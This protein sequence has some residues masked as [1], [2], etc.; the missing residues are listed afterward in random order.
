MLGFT[1]FALKRPVTVLLGLLTL[2]YFGLQS[3]LGSKVELTPEMEMPVM[4]VAT[5]YAGASP[6]DINDLI[7]RPVEDAVATLSGIDEV[8]TYSMENVSIAI[9]QY[10]YGTNMDSAYL[11]LK[12]A[13]DG[14]KSG[15]PEEADEANIIEMDVNAM[16]VVTMAIMGGTDGN[17]YNYVNNEIIP[18][19]E[20]LSSVGEVSLAGGRESYVRIELMAEEMNQYHLDMNTVAQIV[21][22]ADFA[23][24]AGSTKVGKE[25]LS[26]SGGND[27][28]DVESLKNIPIPLADGN[29]IHL[30]DIANVYEALE[31]A[32]SIGRY[33]GQDVISISIQK[34]QSAS[35]VDV[36]RQVV[37][38]MEALKA[39][40]PSL[41]YEMINDSSE[42]IVSSIK[43]V[44]QTLIMAV[45]LSMIVL[46]VFFGDMKASLIVGS[47][48]PV[49]VVVALILMSAM[50]YSLNVISLGALVLGVGMMVDNSIV[51]LES[52][53]RSKEKGGTV[54]DIVVEGARMVINS[55]I[56]ST[57]T[58]CV[59]FIP[60]AL[61]EGLSGQL[62]KPLGF[63][64]VFCMTASLF[65]AVIV[66]P[67]MYMFINPVERTETPVNKG[68]RRL[69]NWYR[70]NIVKLIP[71]TKTVL[72]SSIGLL[73]F[74]LF[75]AS[76][77]GMELMPQ[78]DEGIVNVTITTK[79][80]LTV[81][82]NNEILTKL[83]D[84]VMN[85]EDVDHYLLTY[86]ASGLSISAADAS[87]LTAYLK[88]DRQ[89]S[90]DEVMQK[91]RRETQDMTDC[92]VTIENGSSTGSS[93]MSST[94]TIE[95]DIEGVDYDEVKAVAEDMAAQLKERPDVTQVHS[96]V[97]NAAP[98]VKV[99][100]DPIKA[101]A[102]GLT[103]ASV[104]SVI[105]STLSGVTAMTL[106]T[107]GEDIDVKVEFA[108]DEYDNINQLEGI[109]LTTPAGT[110]VP[111]SDIADIY[112]QDS[113]QT[114]QRSDK[115]YQVAIT[116]QPVEGYEETAETDV[117][118]F[119]AAYTFPAGVSNAA[120]AMDEMMVEELSGLMGA[121]GTAI[122][123][124][125]VV[126]AM[127]FESPKF[128]F[129]VMF[130]IPFSLI[131]AFGCLFIA[132]CK[133]SMV[134]LLG[135]LM[136]IGTVVNNGIL[137][138]DTVN[139][140]RGEMGLQTALVEAGAI[141]MRPIMMTA[142]TTVL[143][144]LPM[145]VGYGDSGTTL[146]G[147]ALVNVGGL[148]AATIL[149]LVLLPTLYRVIDKLGKK[150][151]D[152]GNFIDD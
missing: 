60:L 43:D 102:E 33:N 124:I 24:P 6:E 45:I 62:F 128:S 67:L 15:L 125:F 14:I 93:S 112:Y 42:M 127:Q 126:M 18:E 120:N 13:M 21:G 110:Q 2:V 103:P 149:S 50:G 38:E 74:S 48:I 151:V 146:Q 108:P 137:Y 105:Y 17:L 44:F 140:L 76:R 82:A 11:D 104:G 95:V 86:G 136:L 129:M 59:V 19:L 57:A 80:G 119:A 134:S 100:V 4:L 114:I 115:Q 135:F 148:T 144:M 41:D 68:V 121:I 78:T 46:F 71:K 143:S 7:S 116:C 23:I 36:S 130:T 89:L 64:I 22:A 73:V 66:V 30:S 53:F 29:T 106:N 81:E 49:S 27:Y 77:L 132:N 40:N 101:Q 107:A 75:L 5:T 3:V 131:G 97:E 145:A 9:I 98:V 56:G 85:D 61:M 113:P 79:P 39:E 122:F 31:E 54:Y 96:S 34:Q 87:T 141:R 109:L 147:L 35:A 12:K 90:T 69:Q 37:A 26:V 32:D 133:I 111:L 117:K 10:D 25:S 142:L 1:K 91:W 28:D 150:S 55:L 139:Q 63:T 84:M 123:L 83:E 47:S 70:R 58:T 88:D 20:K 94:N 52:C 99:D 72:F 65:S 152:T 118:Q 16:P 8:G 51:M 92:T 138:V